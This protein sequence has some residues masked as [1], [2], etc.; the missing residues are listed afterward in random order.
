MFRN[1]SIG[2]QWIEW[3]ISVPSLMYIAIS[4]EIKLKP[5][6]NDLVLIIL[7]I[8]VMLF[9]SL[10]SFKW[11]NEKMMIFS[12]LAYISIILV[13]YYSYE[14]EKDVKKIEKLSDFIVDTN[15][16]NLNIIENQ[17]NK[18]KTL[19][20]VLIFIVMPYFPILYTLGAL[21]YIDS[22]TLLIGYCIG[23][24]LGKVLCCSYLTNSHMIFQ[25][26]VTHLIITQATLMKH[27]IE[28]NSTEMRKM[29]ANV[30]HD[31]KTVS[32]TFYYFYLLLL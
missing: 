29:I 11:V 5:T 13:Q 1:V 20:N 7:T 26:E 2:I 23:S 10:V 21:K 17:K 9:A 27:A 16:I 15:K 3:I 19:L 6:I 12:F 24:L 4:I 14:E 32:L 28:V 22:D 25:N 30:A 31:L 8:M 18:K